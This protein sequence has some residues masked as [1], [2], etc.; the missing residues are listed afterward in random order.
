MMGQVRWFYRPEDAVSG[1]LP[2]HGSFELFMSDHEV[3]L[4]SSY[5]RMMRD[6][7]ANLVTRE[8]GL[9]VDRMRMRCDWKM[10]KLT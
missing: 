8:V 3:R 1:R 4:D 6:E 9:S 7:K 2:F 10:T 5:K